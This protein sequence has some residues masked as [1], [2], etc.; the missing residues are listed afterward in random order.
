MFN[1]V[2]RLTALAVEKSI[3]RNI[4]KSYRRVLVTNKR[5]F[6]TTQEPKKEY[7]TKKIF[8]E[9]QIVIAN[10]S[11]KI[12]KIVAQVINLNILEIQQ[13]ITLLRN[14]LGIP[15]EAFKL[16][17]GAGGGGADACSGDASGSGGAAAAA[18]APEPVKEKTMFDIK[19]LAVD[20]KVKIKVI[21]EVRTIT[22]LGLKEAK[23][24]VEKAPVVLKTG[25]KKEEVEAI[26]KVITEAGGV[27][28][29]S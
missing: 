4:N 3:C 27:L 28:E 7:P 15:E 24:L 25:I 22:G 6:C 18:K 5:L 12:K 9:A 17:G 20:A 29:V 26:Q 16:Y 10:P 13:T 14:R 1:R 19:L 21:K 8:E 2:S 23:D 11:D